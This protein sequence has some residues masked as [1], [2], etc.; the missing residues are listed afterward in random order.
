MDPNALRRRIAGEVV[1][2]G[3]RHYEDRRRQ[4]VWNRRTP[5]AR[6]AAIVR[7]AGEGDVVEAVRFA[8]EHGLRVSVRGGGHNWCGTPLRDGA[9][10]LDLSQLSQVDVD[11]AAR[12]AAVQPVVANRDLA[13]RFGAHGL[14]F[15]L[16]HCPTVSLSGY[17]LA[18]GLGW[19]PGVWG[20]ACANV[21][22]IDVVTADGRAR[23]IDAAH[24]A[25]L[26]WAAHG[27]GAGFCAVATRF[28]L[29]LR[30]LPG[31]IHTRT[32]IFPLA[33]LARVAPWVERA[34]AGVP[35][36]VESTLFVAAAPP[37]LAAACAADSGLA[38]VVSATAF[39]D[40]EAEATAALAPFDAG[41]VPDGCLVQVAA[42]PTPFDAL[43]DNVAALLPDERRWLADT[44][45]SKAPLAEVLARLAKA[46][47]SP[48]ASGAVGL[49]GLGLPIGE[50]AALSMPA[51]TFIACYAA[52]ERADHDEANRDWHRRAVAELEPLASG[53]YVGEADL[54]RAG[55]AER[56]YTAETWR[57]LQEI[58]RT[59]D[60]E[61]L[62]CTL[63]DG[64]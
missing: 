21:E 41:P 47:Q 4:L 6:P 30:P 59:Y 22:A 24:D 2:A 28:H 58:R 11:A 46:M 35:A 33:R 43:F 31:A 36:C 1:D 50:V 9:L 38:C 61:G 32:L 20:P 62:F 23:T 17:L 51:P 14:A 53:H 15:P 56:C 39:A 60:P 48:A 16:G 57:R 63:L 49:V 18:G 37:D 55:R 13:R 40:D 12:T 3:E 5:D 8:R 64:V 29:R 25:D 7:V 34:L 54:N 44:F 19:N 45:W 10:L 42:Q 27:A 52:W 26:F